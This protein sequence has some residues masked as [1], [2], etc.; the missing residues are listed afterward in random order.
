MKL[1]YISLIVLGSLINSCIAFG[2]RHYSYETQER[3]GN[4]HARMDEQ[5]EKDAFI[6]GI[7]SEMTPEELSA[8]PKNPVKRRGLTLI[9]Y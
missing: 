1:A 7:V 3:A 4:K 8:S 5:T 9:V 6:N 2:P